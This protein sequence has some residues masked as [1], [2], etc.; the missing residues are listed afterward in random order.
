M[1]SGQTRGDSHHVIILVKINNTC[2]NLILI[3]TMVEGEEGFNLGE[4][5]HGSYPNTP[6]T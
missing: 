5:G 1:C 2:G 4:E 3:G 6:I